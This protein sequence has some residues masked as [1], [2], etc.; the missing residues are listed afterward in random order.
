[1]DAYFP[2]LISESYLKREAEHVEGF[3]L[4]P[5]IVTHAGGKELDEPLIIWPTSETVI[6]ET[7]AR[8]AGNLDG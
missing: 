6:G 2:P 5:A 4:E 7:M 3:S 1:M 8:A